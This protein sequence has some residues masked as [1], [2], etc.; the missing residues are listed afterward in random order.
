MLTTQRTCSCSRDAHHLTD[1]YEAI[2]GK[3]HGCQDVDECSKDDSCGEGYV[4]ANTRGSFI[5]NCMSPKIESDGKC[6]DVAVPNT[7]AEGEEDGE[8]AG[9]ETKESPKDEL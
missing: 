1:R 3:D 2:P 8:G 9:E 4:C 7:T 6:H 5:C